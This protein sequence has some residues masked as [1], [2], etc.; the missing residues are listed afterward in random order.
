[1]IRDSREIAQRY[2]LPEQPFL[3][4]MASAFDLFGVLNQSR[5][6]RLLANQLADIECLERNTLK[7]SW[8]KVGLKLYHAIKLYEDAER[9]SGLE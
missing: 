9:E 2:A 3:H 1:M 7:D 8:A 5:R 6:E 4:G